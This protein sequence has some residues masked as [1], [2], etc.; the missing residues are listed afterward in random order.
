MDV[1]GKK[2]GGQEEKLPSTIVILGSA[3]EINHFL[4]F[5]LREFWYFKV[6]R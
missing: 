2:L 4:N 1:E 5:L 3:D 6:L